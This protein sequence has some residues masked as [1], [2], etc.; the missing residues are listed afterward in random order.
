MDT[1]PKIEPPKPRRVLSV[2]FNEDKSCFAIGLETGFMGKSAPNT[3]RAEVEKYADVYT[4]VLRT[5]QGT[6]MLKKGENPSKIP[7]TRQR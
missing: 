1:R 7:D 6:S 4:V 2:T 3:N 5:E